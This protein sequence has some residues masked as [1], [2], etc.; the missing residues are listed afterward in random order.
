MKRP[1]RGWLVWAVWVGMLA[2]L[3]WLLLSPDVPGATAALIPPGGSFYFAKAAHLGWYAAL[4]FLGVLLP[5]GGRLWALLGLGLHAVLTEWLQSFVPGRSGA[6]QDVLIDW[7]GALSGLLAGWA[8][9]RGRGPA[10]SS[11]VCPAPGPS[12]GILPPAECQNGRAIP[13][14]PAPTRLHETR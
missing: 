11:V 7:A 6:V 1:R 13:A 9:T 2:V 4:A 5:G 10:G 14:D 8:F 3:T 12:E